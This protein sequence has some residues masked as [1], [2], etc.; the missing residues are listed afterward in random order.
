MGAF[1]PK[2]HPRVCFTTMRVKLPQ[3]G[4]PRDKKKPRENKNNAE[5]KTSIEAAMNTL[6]HVKR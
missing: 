1:H 6:T 5:K 3:E 4:K 2:Y